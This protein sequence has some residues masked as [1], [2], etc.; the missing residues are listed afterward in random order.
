MCMS[1]VLLKYQN[2]LSLVFFLAVFLTHCGQWGCSLKFPL[3]LC[4][5]LLPN[6]LGFSFSCYHLISFLLSF[7]VH[8]SLSDSY[9]SKASDFK[10]FF[11]MM[12]LIYLNGPV[13]GQFQTLVPQT[14]SR[15]TKLRIPKGCIREMERLIHNLV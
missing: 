8:Y 12:L 6:V 3:Y 1:L 9:L 2:H 11:I 15:Y 7:G 14:V 4:N 10:F 5:F 13:D